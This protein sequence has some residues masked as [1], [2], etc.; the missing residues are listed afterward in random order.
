MK[1]QGAAFADIVWRSTK[2]SL[3]RSVNTSATVVIVLVA[4]YILGPESTKDFSLTLI[5]GMVA[6]TYSSLLLASPLLIFIEERQR[7]NAGK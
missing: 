5:I 7:K 2:Q 3:T 4:L 6:G 1:H